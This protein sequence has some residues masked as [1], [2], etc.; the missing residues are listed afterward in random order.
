[1]VGIG[2]AVLETAEIPLL[3]SPKN[4]SRQHVQA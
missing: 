3:S 4:G 2:L 1:M